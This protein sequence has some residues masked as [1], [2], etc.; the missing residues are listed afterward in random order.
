LPGIPAAPERVQFRECIP[1]RV[2]HAKTIPRRLLA[3]GAEFV[4]CVEMRQK[5]RTA[6][7]MQ[8]PLKA[9]YAASSFVSA[10]VM[11]MIAGSSATIKK[12]YASPVRPPP[13]RPAIGRA[14]T[15]EAMS[16]SGTVVGL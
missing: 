6:L 8:A 14:S 10:A 15:I 4:S 12:P 2:C 9:G 5:S 1:S 11:A 16:E 7:E 3:N 13:S